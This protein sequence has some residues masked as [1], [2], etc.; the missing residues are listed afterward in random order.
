[1][2]LIEK[3][4]EILLTWEMWHY[5]SVLSTCPYPSIP[6]LKT[7]N[8]QWAMV[9]K[10]RYYGNGR[11]ETWQGQPWRN[12]PT[13]HSQGHGKGQKCVTSK[14]PGGTMDRKAETRDISKWK[15]WVWQRFDNKNF[16]GKSD[17]INFITIFFKGH[18]SQEIINVN[19]FMSVWKSGAHRHS[20]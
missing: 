11:V 10:Q 19:Y 13:I 5:L 3:I 18:N 12:P 16:C 17:I 1:M 2:L 7:I 4:Y 6:P 8:C 15:E 9:R 14:Y 20:N